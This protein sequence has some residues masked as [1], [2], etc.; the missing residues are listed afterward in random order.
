[1]VTSKSEFVNMAFLGYTPQLKLEQSNESKTILLWTA[2]TRS[3]MS[4]P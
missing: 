2:T 3:G 4:T 1:M